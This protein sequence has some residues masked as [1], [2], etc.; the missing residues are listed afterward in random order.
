MILHRYSH[1]RRSDKVK[2]EERKER[3]SDDQL[4]SW[5]RQQME[6]IRRYVE[7]FLKYTQVCPTRVS[8]TFWTRHSSM[9]GVSVLHKRP[10]CNNMDI[11]TWIRK[12]L[13]FKVL[14]CNGHKDTTTHMH[15]QKFTHTHTERERHWLGSYWI[16][17]E[18]SS[19]HVKNRRSKPFNMIYVI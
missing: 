15:E 12:I 6:T 10:G 2:E 9:I 3:W 4:C 18:Y 5:T 17:F 16:G 1:T 7:I 19:Y 8:D 13:K 14:V 11:A